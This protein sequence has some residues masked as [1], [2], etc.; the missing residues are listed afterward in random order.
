MIG[1]YCK[2]VRALVTNHR[3]GFLLSCS[4]ASIHA[5]DLAGSGTGTAEAVGEGGG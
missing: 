4:F 5:T 1:D 3:E 2:G